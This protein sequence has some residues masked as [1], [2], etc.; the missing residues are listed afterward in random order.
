VADIFA[1]ETPSFGDVGPEKEVGHLSKVYLTNT[2]LATLQS[3]R[4]LERRLPVT[5]PPARLRKSRQGRYHFS[6]PYFRFYFRFIDPYQAYL[7]S[8]SE[9]LLAGVKQGLRAFVGQTAFEQLA[10]EW[11]RKQGRVEAL[12]FEPEAVGSHCSRRVQVDAVAISW[13]TGDILLGECKWTETAIDRKVIREL[14]EEK[15]PKVIKDL[16]AYGEV[17]NVHYALFARRGFTDAARA[18][19]EKWQMLLVDLALLDAVL[20]RET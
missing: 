12:P 16:Q 5:I 20:Q 9:Q 3:L 14:L 18:Y 13:R 17:W 10:R 15:A 6:D 11:L 1:G 19:A 7:P 2:Y 4:L 8:E